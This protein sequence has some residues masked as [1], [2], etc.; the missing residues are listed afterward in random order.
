MRSTVF[1][2]VLSMILLVGTGCPVG[3]EHPLGYPGTEKIDRDL[4][5]TWACQVEEGE[6][7]R[8]QISEGTANSYE[9]TV[10][11]RGSTYALET[12]VLT[13]WV[14]E[15]DKKKFVYF[16]PDNEESYYL[17]AY[18]LDGKQTLRTWDVG[19]LVGGVDAVT[20]TEAFRKEVSASLDNPEC[21]SSE[22][23]W[24]RE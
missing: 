23:V 3:I 11:E 8:I 7:Q 4:I 9:V 14:T 24:V 13:G 17:Y 20:S 2:L 12:D 18:E 19:L 22:Q 15:L 1:A 5:G 10:L 16:K 21:L 6:V